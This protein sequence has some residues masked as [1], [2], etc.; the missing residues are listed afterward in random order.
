M[1]EIDKYIEKRDW[2]EDVFAELS[3]HDEIVYEVREDLV[4]EASKEFKKIMASV[5]PKE[6]TL[7]VPIIAESSAGN[8]WG[9]MQKI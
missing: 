9:N 4:E 5:I 7:G 1:I 8:S 3:V 6:K 2:Q